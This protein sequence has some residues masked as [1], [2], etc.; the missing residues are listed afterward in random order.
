M[1][2]LPLNDQDILQIQ[3]H[4]ITLD[5]QSVGTMEY[6]RAST[7]TWLT[8]G[9]CQFINILSRRYTYT[10]FFN[11]NILTNKVLLGSLLFS[12]GT[13]TLGVYGPYISDVLEFASIG[14]LDWLHVWGAAGIFLAVWEGIKI[15][16]RS[17]RKRGNSFTESEFTRF[18]RFRPGKQRASAPQTRIHVRAHRCSWS[19]IRAVCSLIPLKKVSFF[20]QQ[21]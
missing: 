11:R 17:G 19:H 18:L 15:L 1:I 20:L 14:F 7:M 3:T 12:M 16:R 10:S 9:Y 2:D 4:G 13:V 6:A 8:I 21:R 5:Q